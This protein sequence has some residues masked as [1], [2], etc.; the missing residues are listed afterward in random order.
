MRQGTVP[1]IQTQPK[2]SIT[3]LRAQPQGLGWARLVRLQPGKL[4]KVAHGAQLRINVAGQQVR[5]ALERGDVALGVV[6]PEAVRQPVQHRR[7]L[8]CFNAWSSRLA[9]EQVSTALEGGDW[10]L[11][12]VV[13]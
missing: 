5:A 10:R 3:N 12:G 7:H 9:T 6:A 2:H 4:Q 1:L 11:G 8:P 13:P